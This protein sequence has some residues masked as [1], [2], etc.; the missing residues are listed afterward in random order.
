MG[1]PNSPK[2]GTKQFG[3]RL[4]EELLLRADALAEQLTDENPGM[5]YTRAD[6][7]RI[8]L[9]RHLP[10]LSLEGRNRAPGPGTTGAI[11]HSQRKGGA[12]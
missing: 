10:P 3:I 11:K 7:I 9:A 1:M 2:E 12:R 4:P 8:T 6:A 5:S